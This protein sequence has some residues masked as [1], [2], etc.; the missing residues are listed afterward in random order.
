VQETE[1]R[2]FL[3]VKDSGPPI[4][5]EIQKKMF[6]AFYTTKSRDRGTGIGLSAATHV[7]ERHSGYI[8]LDAK[9]D[10]PRMVISLP[11]IPNSLNKVA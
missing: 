1:D 3:S 10:H 7:L 4:P 9:C 11:K 6:K 8:E 5:D 2:W